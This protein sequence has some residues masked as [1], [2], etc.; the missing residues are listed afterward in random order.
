MRAV[1]IERTGG[2]EVMRLVDIEVGAPAAGQ[3]LLRHTAIGVNF[4]DTYHR[5]GLYPGRMPS[6]LGTEAA[7]VVEAVGEGVTNVRVGDR[8]A[9]FSF[10]RK[11]Y[12]THRLI[13]A[14]WLT[15]LPDTISDEQAAALWL[16]GAT[17]EFLV[18]RCAR[19]QA[20]DTILVPAAAGGVG[21]LLCQWLTHI[22]ATV[23]GVVGSE[24][25]A[26]LARTAGAAHIL[27][28]YA[29]MAARVR[30]LT[31]G[32]GVPVVLDGV[33]K[34]TFDAALDCLAPRGLMVSFGNASGAVPPF[35]VAQLAS[36]GSLFLTRPGLAHYYATADDRS[37]G[38]ARLLEMIGAG[39]LRAHVGQRYALADVVRAHQDLEARRT[40]GASLLIP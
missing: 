39:V 30:E 13:D 26:A 3:V 22:G 23:I 28:G 40:I 7:A 4:I 24:A 5:S 17:V 11:A 10:D 15:P 19:V 20:G 25:K 27:V 21:T 6:R 29:D 2:P 34:D 36:K 33:G 16:K 35:Q 18:E 37:K 31:D 38:F 32:R 9:Y 12:A 1:E 14:G 8:V